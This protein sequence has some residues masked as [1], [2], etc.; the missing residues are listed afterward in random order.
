MDEALID[1]LRLEPHLSVRQLA[2]RL[3]RTEN[4]IRY[5]LRKLTNAGVIKHEGPTKSGKWVI[6]R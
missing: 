1:L 4:S 2:K 5:H 3:N 6:K